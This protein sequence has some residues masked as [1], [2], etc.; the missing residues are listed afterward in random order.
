MATNLCLCGFLG[1]SANPGKCRCT[2]DQIARYRGKI[3]GPLLDRIDMHIEVSRPDFDKANE[4]SDTAASAAVRDMVNR[5][6]EIQAQRFRSHSRI[7][8]NAQMGVREIDRYCQ[9][10]LDA[11]RLLT[12]SVERLGLSIR[13]WHKILKVARTIA[14][15]A[16]APDIETGHVAEAVQFRRSDVLI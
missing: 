7:F 5:A 10:N 8:A 9:I 12:K 4:K 14:D 6:Q 15:L 11:K 13:A 1:D 2:P 3:S 16:E